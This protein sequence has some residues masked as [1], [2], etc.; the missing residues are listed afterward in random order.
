MSN[1]QILF[2]LSLSSYKYIILIVKTDDP[3]VPNFKDIVNV[4]SAE[5]ESASL[6]VV[7]E[8]EDEGISDISTNETIINPSSGNDKYGP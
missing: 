6:D 5:E 8:I 7:D 1:C 4:E 3:A 2:L